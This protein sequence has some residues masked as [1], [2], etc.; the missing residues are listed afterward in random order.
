MEIS[1]CPARNRKRPSGLN[2]KQRPTPSTL[3]LPLTPSS[4]CPSSLMCNKDTPLTLRCV[5]ISTLCEFSFLSLCIYSRTCV[6]LKYLI[7][8]FGPKSA[9]IRCL[10]VTFIDYFKFHRSLLLGKYVF[11]SNCVGTYYY[12][13]TRYIK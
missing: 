8:N 11:F 2:T 6:R 10:F 12:F 5:C 1:K 4:S 3:P 13:L 7:L 9:N